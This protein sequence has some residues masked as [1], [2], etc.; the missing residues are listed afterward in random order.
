M[1]EWESMM[2]K[3]WFWMCFDEIVFMLQVDIVS[4]LFEFMRVYL[5]VC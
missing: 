2:W 4:Y 5:F 3:F 1:M